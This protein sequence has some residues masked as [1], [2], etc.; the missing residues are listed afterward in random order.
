[1]KGKAGKFVEGQGRSAA[2]PRGAGIYFR[3]RDKHT[4]T[5]DRREMEQFLACGVGSRIDQGSDIGVAG[6]E[7]SIEWRVD[8]LEGLQILKPVDIGSIGVHGG[9]PGA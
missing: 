6:S 8:L 3:N 5:V 7:N 4:E 1:M 9:L 2:G